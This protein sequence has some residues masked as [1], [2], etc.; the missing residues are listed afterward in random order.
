MNEV[1]AGIGLIVVIALGIDMVL[2]AMK[3]RNPLLQRLRHWRLGRAE[4]RRALRREASQLRREAV[5]RGNSAPVPLD[6]AP[7]PKPAVQW[8]GNVAHLS[9]RDPSRRHNRS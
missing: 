2:D 8:E 9:H 5:Q 7:A 3:L 1:V 4:S 6:E